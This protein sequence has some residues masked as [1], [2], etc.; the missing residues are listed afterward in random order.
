MRFYR[1]AGEE[2]KSILRDFFLIKTAPVR[3]LLRDL[4]RNPVLGDTM[5]ELVDFS[6]LPATQRATQELEYGGLQSYQTCASARGLAR[7]VRAWPARAPA[8]RRRG[9]C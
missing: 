3:Q 6:L 5:D 7:D 2:S 1:V 4:L 9:P 8:S